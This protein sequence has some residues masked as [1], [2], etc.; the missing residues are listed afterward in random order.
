M[1]TYDE[2]VKENEQLLKDYYIVSK[3]CVE[4]K[5]EIERLTE[6]NKQLEEEIDLEVDLQTQRKRQIIAESQ[7]FI[8]ELANKNAELQKQVD[9]LKERAKIDLENERNWGKIQTKQAVKDAAKEIFSFIVNQ[10]DG[11]YFLHNVEQFIAE[12]YGVEV[13]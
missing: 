8:D 5:A 1:K 12:K 3:T 6:E 13:E 9:E 7:E 4:Q 10:Y 11:E 2:L